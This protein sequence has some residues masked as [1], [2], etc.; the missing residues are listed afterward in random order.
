MISYVDY[1]EK[2]LNEMDRLEARFWGLE[3]QES[4]LDEIDKNSMI[5]VALNE[6]NCVVGF[7]HAQV[8][9]DLLEIHNILV[10]EDEQKKGIGW[11]L[12]KEMLEKGQNLGI[13]NSIANAVVIKGEYINSEKLLLNFGYKP[14]YRVN[15]YWEAI[16]PGYYCKQCDSKPCYCDNVVFLK[17]LE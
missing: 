7:I 14:I 5:R 9:G 10:R 12:L 1:N 2:Y 4:I 17:N 8:I 6:Q 13:K 16:Y 15:G 11:H 3:Y